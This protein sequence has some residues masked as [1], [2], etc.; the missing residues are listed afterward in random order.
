MPAEGLVAICS[1]TR[2]HDVGGVGQLD[3]GGVPH[4]RLGGVLCAANWTLWMIF[5]SVRRELF[6]HRELEPHRL[7]NS[8]KVLVVPR[9]LCL[10]ICPWP[11]WNKTRKLQHNGNGS[12]ND[13]STKIEQKTCLWI[14][15]PP[16][17]HKLAKD[18]SL[19][20]TVTAL[21]CTTLHMYK[22]QSFISTA[23]AWSLV[24]PQTSRKPQ[25]V[26]NIMLRRN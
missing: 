8:N 16:K 19:G 12:A 18:E 26:R 14:L 6:L 4:L 2:T 5:Q 3:C 1:A 22:P 7:N 13:V 10:H 21:R 17:N 11:V 24:S 25:T 23:E 20:I 9:K 15:K